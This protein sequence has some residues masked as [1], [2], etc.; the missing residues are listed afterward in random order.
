M[1]LVNLGDGG[2]EG[3]EGGEA[4]GRQGCIKRVI[5]L[6]FF[7]LQRAHS[8]ASRVHMS[9]N[10]ELSTAR[11]NK[12]EPSGNNAKTMT[13]NSSLLPAKC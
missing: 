13:S 9:S 3:W 11:C 2:G 10:I 7:L 5:W 12:H 8:L 4:G 6:A 1:I